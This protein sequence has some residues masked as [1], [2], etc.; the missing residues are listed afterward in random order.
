M[1]VEADP[2]AR[3]RGVVLAALPPASA[4][5]ALL[6]PGPGWQIAALAPLVAVLGL[7]HGALDHR[8]AGALWPLEGARVHAVFLAAYT[9]L[10]GAVLGLWWLAPGA[11]L[12]LFLAYSGL[13]FADDW[14]GDLGRTARSVAGLAVVAVP[15]VAHRAE[16]AAIFAHLAPAPAA[17]AVARGLALAGAGLLAGLGALLA[18]RARRQPG[19]VAELAA[20]LAAGLILP[21][22]VYF[23]LYFCAVHSPRHFLTATARLGLGARDGVAA[24]LPITAVTLAGAGAA[25]ALLLAEGVPADTAT[26]RA[27]FVGLAALTVPHMALV[28]RFFHESDPQE[29]ARAG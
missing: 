22:L 10:A 4:A 26:L 14:R 16:V 3:H 19:L 15:A 2:I 21:P 7:P 24:A 23:V 27:V 12:G 25:A 8:L 1:T 17:E 29:R 13:H 9:G 28:D 18:S 5:L 11:A 6:A 20:I